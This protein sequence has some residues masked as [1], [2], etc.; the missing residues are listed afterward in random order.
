MADMNLPQR[1]TSSDDKTR[2]DFRLDFA[3]LPKSLLDV[4]KVHSFIKVSGEQLDA[5]DLPLSSTAYV[6]QSQSTAFRQEEHEN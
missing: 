6:T 1:L 2:Q 3:S 4:P 5:Q